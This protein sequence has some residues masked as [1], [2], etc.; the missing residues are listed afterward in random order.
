MGGRLSCAP[1]AHKLFEKEAARLQVRAAKAVTR[2]RARI[3]GAQVQ[4]RA[5]GLFLFTAHRITQKPDRRCSEGG[6]R[7]R[8]LADFFARVLGQVYRLLLQ[9]LGEP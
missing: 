3:G 5:Q 8:V 4:N 2:P 9:R 7:D 1:V 6:G